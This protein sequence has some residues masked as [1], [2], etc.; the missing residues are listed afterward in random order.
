MTLVRLVSAVAAVTL[1]TGC[2]L[3]NTADDEQVRGRG[4]RA[5]DPYSSAASGAISLSLIQ[6]NG[7]SFTPDGHFV[8]PGSLTLPGYPTE[9]QGIAQN[10]YELIPTPQ[11]GTM[12][13]LRGQ[14]YFLNQFIA[15][16]TVF[17]LH[18][19]YNDRAAPATWIRKHSRFKSLD[20]SGLTVNREDWRLEAPPLWK[21]ETYF[22]NAAWMNRTDSTFT[23][24]VLDAAG[25][26]RTS[27]TYTRQDFLAE[28][29]YSGRT[30]VSW[31]ANL[32]APPRFPGDPE[33]QVSPPNDPVFQT[34][35]KVALS[36]SANPFKTFDMPDIA[37]DGVIR[38]RWNLMPDEP[39]LFPVKF[40]RAEEVPQTCFKI[41]ADGFATNEP[42]PCGF[43]LSQKVKFNNPRNGKFY[44]P[45][46]NIDFKVSLRD[47]EGNGL[48]SGEGLPSLTEYR[49]GL[50]NGFLYFNEF[51]LVTMREQ[52]SS[53]SGYL[54]AG[55]LH[56]MRLTPKQL[57]DYFRSPEVGEPHFYAD[58]PGI[59]DFLPAGADTP[60]PTRF[61]VPLP[62]NAKAG[63]YVLYLKGHRYFMGERLNRLDAFFF[64][65]GQE[66]PTAYPGR[67]GNCQIC[68]NGVLS[69]GNVMHGL[70]VDNVEGCKACHN[71]NVFGHVG[72]LVHRIHTSS[73]KYPMEKRDCSVCHLSRESA[74]N[75]S[76]TNCS[77]CHPTPHGN[78]Y[79][80]LQF[81]WVD[82][83]PNAYTT[84]GAACHITS[85]PSQHILPA[86]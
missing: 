58:D 2:N 12:T 26:L 42:A 50:N 19:D 3:L 60:P 14:R 74:L 56:E 61:T 18:S 73:T 47:G 48:H 65:V 21:R 54:V 76:I 81:R 49:A 23:V 39:F 80:D 82:Q 45:G 10:P 78:S 67:V 31:T 8:S 53:E 36:T 30:R 7:C 1:V 83:T 72:D 77:G 57:T 43:G 64:Q 63:T 66:A 11:T 69:L 41:G 51:P 5:F 33:I 85:A 13:V 52:S 37:G 84:C 68:H 20:W 4:A 70:S 17:G 34:T 75:P 55:P 6:F 22:E 29:P 44:A 28:S 24:E 62:A 46:E 32:I 38:V 27:Q 40:V 15:M 35:V 71:E 79:S 59:R 9:C 25:T 16:H 86:N